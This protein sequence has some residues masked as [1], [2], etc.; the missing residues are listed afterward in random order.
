MRT[1][2]SAMWGCWCRS[3]GRRSGWRPI[4]GP[5]RSERLVKAAESDSVL[6]AVPKPGQ[7]V[8]PDAALATDPWWRL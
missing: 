3:T 1:A 7:R 5:S 6:I 4:R 8:Q 2:T